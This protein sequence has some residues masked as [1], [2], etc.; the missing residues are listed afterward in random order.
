MTKYEVYIIKFNYLSY[1]EKIKYGEWTG[2]FGTNGFLI[3]KH[4]SVSDFD[5]R[6][7]LDTWF[8]EKWG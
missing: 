4:L 5:R 2:K 7:L 8:N 1:V 6:L 3:Y